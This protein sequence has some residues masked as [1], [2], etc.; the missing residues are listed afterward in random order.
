VIVAPFSPDLLAPLSRLYILPAVSSSSQKW[1]AKLLKAHSR[2]F[3]RMNSLRLTS[4]EVGHA[5]HAVRAAAKKAKGGCRAKM[6]HETN[7]K[8]TAHCQISRLCQ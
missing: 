2:T 4:A 6:K 7:R 8:R 1:N 3:H 5:V